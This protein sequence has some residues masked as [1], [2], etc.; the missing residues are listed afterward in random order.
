MSI[1]LVVL[2]HAG[3]GAF[4]GGFVG[5]DVFFV[6]SGYLI[7]GLLLRESRETGGINLGNFFARRIR[8]LLP[9]AAIVMAFT[10]AIGFWLLAPL[11]RSEL[12]VDARFA[13]LYVANW[14]FGDQAIAYSDVAVTDSLLLH[15]WSLAVEEQFYVIWPLMIALVLWAGRRIARMDSSRWILVS[16]VAVVVVSFGISVRET[17]VNP[18]GAYF[19]TFGRLWEMGAGALLAILLSR[20]RVFPTWLSNLAGTIGLAAILISALTYSDATRFPGFAA[21]I[22]VVG[23]ALIIATGA[24]PGVRVGALLSLRPLSQ[25]GRYSYAWY[26]WHWPLIGIFLLT[27]DRWGLEVSS[28]WTI[29]VAVLTSL[30]V[31]VASHHVIENPIRFARPLR[32]ANRPN[33]ALGAM[34][35]AIP[36][37][38]GAVL[39]VAGDT[40][41]GAVAVVAPPLEPTPTT[42]VPEN[43]SDSDT[44]DSTRPAT[45]PDETSA[46]E[47][48][49]TTTQPLVPTNVT[50]SIPDSP[51]SP[52]QAQQD[53]VGR[54]WPPL[55]ISECYAD[56][57]TTAVEPA[58]NCQ[59]GVRSGSSRIVVL[60]DSH[61]QHWLPAIH[62]SALANDWSVVAWVKSA[63]AFSGASGWSN[64]FERPNDECDEWQE[65]IFD[66]LET[67][68]ADAVILARSFRYSE[69]VLDADNNKIEDRQE[70]VDTYAEGYA[71]THERLTE[72]FGKVLVFRDTPWSFANVSDCLSRNL[73]APQECAFELDEHTYLDDIL[74]DAEVQAVGVDHHA[75]FTDA[76]CST[77][78][79]QVVTSDGVIK[80]RD[81]NH[82]TGTFSGNLAPDVERVILELLEQE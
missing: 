67:I 78:P 64:Q 4:S 13:S 14:R 43:G 3:V 77:D 59:I 52:E 32:R 34:F 2:Y 41:G 39:A 10:V 17:E 7:T 60:G 5:V 37:V 26:L 53:W 50:T 40:G 65:N 11:Q 72:L 28:A 38:I 79:C 69:R 75:D 47:T 49:T 36:I 74:Y 66:E 31:A 21:L 18:G 22:P 6:L 20:L 56:L 82:L 30:V 80:Y 58:Q 63:C 54:N 57:E 1:V 76:V 19:S 33:F 46:A 55:R 70:I 8:R 44:A 23:T 61:M 68:E 12:I 27:R 24:R 71:E 42:T 73:T 45:Q 62:A 81:G 51:M 15:Y 35:M 9:L 25:F 48:T 16:I 29:T